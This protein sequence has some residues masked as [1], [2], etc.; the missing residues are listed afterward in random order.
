MELKK[1][2]SINFDYLDYLDY[3]DYSNY[4]NYYERIID[5]NFLEIDIQLDNI[6]KTIDNSSELKKKLVKEKIIKEK[7][8][9]KKIIKEKIIKKKKFE[10]ESINIKYIEIKENRRIK[11]HSKNTKESKRKKNFN[12]GMRF[13]VVD[14][15]SS[16]DSEY[17]S[18]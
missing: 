13:Y 7:I 11:E 6:K 2:S 18:D 8:I 16:E 3:F 12:Y 9:K 10:G 1:G 4:F 5:R 17:D 15:S 14:T